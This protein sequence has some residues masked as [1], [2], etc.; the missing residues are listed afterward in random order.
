MHPQSSDEVQI[1][2]LSHLANLLENIDE[3][4]GL[5]KINLT[6]LELPQALE[7]SNLGEMRILFQPQ[8]VQV[9]K[10]HVG[11]VSARWSERFP[12]A[13]RIENLPAYVRQLPAGAFYAPKAEHIGSRRNLKKWVHLQNLTHPG[14]GK[15]LNKLVDHD[16]HF[17]IGEFGWS[18]LGGQVFLDRDTYLDLARFVSSRTMDFVIR[19]GIEPAFGY[20]CTTCGARNDHGFGRWTRDRHLGYFVE[21]LFAL[22]FI[23][24]PE[25]IFANILSKDGIPTGSINKRHEPLWLQATL[26]R[27]VQSFN[28]MRRAC[29]H[30]D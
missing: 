5:T 9:G 7:G 27:G 25:L 11:M 28:R 17:Q 8:L 1:F 4:A 20:R 24:R 26:T 14:M 29:N 19:E 23:G 13:P 10:S 2:V 15:Y 6:E 12:T 30:E 18:V 21:R 16:P 22:Y 3:C